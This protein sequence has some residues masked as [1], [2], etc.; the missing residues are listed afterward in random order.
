V[1]SVVEDLPAWLSSAV[2]RFTLWDLDDNPASDIPKR[3]TGDKRPQLDHIPPRTRAPH[4]CAERQVLQA[5]AIID[6]IRRR[7]TTCSG[8]H[9]VSH[10]P[11][12]CIAPGTSAAA[13]PAA[14][15]FVLAG[16]VAGQAG[17]RRGGASGCLLALGTRDVAYSAGLVSAADDGHA[18]DE[19]KATGST[20][21]RP[22]KYHP[23]RRPGARRTPRPRGRAPGGLTSVRPA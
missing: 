12:C 19:C 20:P 14:A 8:R 22:V 11:G 10:G 23:D 5:P 16:E 4:V 2:G 9:R 17:G 1:L 21:S 3:R 18:W 6:V 15:A 13:T 7:A